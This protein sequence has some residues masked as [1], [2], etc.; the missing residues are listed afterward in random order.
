VKSRRPVN[1]IVGRLKIA[2]PE[3]IHTLTVDASY[4][5]ATCVI[6]VGIVIQ[7]RA[8]GSGRGPITDQIAEAHIGLSHG[9]G[10]MFAVLRALETANR[11]GAWLHE[12]QASFRLQL[13]EAKPS[14]TFSFGYRGQE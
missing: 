6:V 13:D 12:N 4:D 1:S 10:E 7:S 5:A 14:G 11:K 9:Q 8:G 3:W 2:M